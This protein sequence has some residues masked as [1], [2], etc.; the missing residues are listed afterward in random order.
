MEN[1]KVTQEQAEH[2][3]GSDANRSQLIELITE[4]ANGEYEQ[5]QLRQDILDHPICF[6]EDQT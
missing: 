2:W 1:I 6:N 5:E 4:L 3:L